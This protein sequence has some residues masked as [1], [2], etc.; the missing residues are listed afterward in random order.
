MKDSSSSEPAVSAITQLEKLIADW[1]LKAAEAEEDG[2][3]CCALTQQHDARDLSDLVDTLR[4]S[5]LSLR[6][7]R[8]PERNYARDY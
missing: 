3:L 6:Q 1:T 8:P 5:L 7:S 2:D 4:A